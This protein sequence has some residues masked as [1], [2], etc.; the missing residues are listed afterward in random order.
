MRYCEQNMPKN[1]AN[2]IYMDHASA[3]PVDERVLKEME[4]YW[5]ECFFNPGSIHAGGVGAK[6][7]LEGY[8]KRLAKVLECKA[9][10]VIFTSGGTETNALAILGVIRGRIKEGKGAELHAVTSTIEHPSVLETFDMI[11]QEY[12]VA[13]SY[14]APRSD[15]RIRAEDV[16]AVLEEN[17]V[18]VS[19]VYANSEIGTIQPLR[20]IARAIKEGGGKP[21]F[22]SDASQAPEYLNAAPGALGV[23]LE[24]LDAQKVYG[25]KGVGALVVRED[26][27]IEPLIYGGEQERGKRPGTEP[28]PLVAGFARAMEIAAQNRKEESERVKEL[29]DR[30]ID[31]VL[32]LVPGAELNGDREMRLPNN[33]NIHLPGIDAEYAALQL[34]ARGIGVGTRT[35]CMRGESDAGSY[36]LRELHKEVDV[37]NSSLRITLGRQTSKSD[38]D[39]VIKA[40]AEVANV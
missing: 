5:T 31:G 14:V 7:A 9:G 21:I 20:E 22:H 35:A 33:A 24:T 34:D 10:E 39:K 25:P 26:V 4:P 3:T 8:R 2:F 19:V 18:L 1:M 36:V 27:R 38:V 13:V 28:V 12:G 23:D 37:S 32:E 15:G 11:E 29:R 17:T 30:L 6:E 40:V 16:R